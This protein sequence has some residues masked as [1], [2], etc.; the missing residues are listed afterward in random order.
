MRRPIRIE[1]LAEKD[2]EELY[3]AF[4]GKPH[5]KDAIPELSA[6][7]DGEFALVDDGTN[8]YLAYRR[9]DKIIKIQGIVV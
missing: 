5:K 7:G 8:H 2:K 1:K 3:N 6:L 4:A 9:G